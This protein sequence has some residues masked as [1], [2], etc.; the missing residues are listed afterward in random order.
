VVEGPAA[1]NYLIRGSGRAL[2]NLAWE[3]HSITLK[4]DCAAPAAIW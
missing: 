4:F 3:A 2:S 1:R